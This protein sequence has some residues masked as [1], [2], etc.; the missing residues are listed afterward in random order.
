MTDLQP[1][2]TVSEEL[3]YCAVH[4]DRETSLRCNKCGRYMCVECAVPTPVGYRCRECVRGLEDR[5]YKASQN[6]NLIVGATCA[7]LTGVAG[8]IIGAIHLPLLFVLLLGLPAGAFIAEAG[9]RVTQRRRGRQT[10]LIGAGSAVAGG[11]IGGLAQV[12]LFYMSVSGRAVMPPLN[13]VFML[14]WNNFS[15]L[16]FIGMVAVAIYG[17]FKMRM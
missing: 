13:L 14:V 16:L 2:S 1:A 8:A 17:R 12:Y 3:T 10:P 5:Y 11:L 9:L 15:L 4:P 7:A 6:D